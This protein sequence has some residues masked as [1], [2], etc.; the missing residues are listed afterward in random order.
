MATATTKGIFAAIA[1]ITTLSLA[2]LARPA[3]AFDITYNFTI[4]INS[5][6]YDAQG[7]KKGDIE[8]GNFTYDDTKLTGIGSEYVSKSQGNLSIQFDFLNR[9]Y[10]EK[11]DLNYGNTTYLYDY[12]VAFFKDG[13]LIGLDFLVVPSQFNPP[14]PDVGFRIFKDA[15][16][17][18]A[19]DN[20]H[21]GTLV[22][23]VTYGD[24]AAVPEPSEIGG[25][26]VA[27]G[28]ISFWMIKK[29]KVT[30]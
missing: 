8:S 17:V 4:Q 14:Q 13:T 21:S 6:A 15:F 29:S 27:L 5:D 22:G 20:F 11:N 25:A 10:T 26:V 16:Y 24:T 2:T 30:R 12:P 3:Q 7:V 19:T 1:S 18:G 28:L 23:A 9:Y